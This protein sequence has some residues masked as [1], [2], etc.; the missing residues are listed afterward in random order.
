MVFGTCAT[1]IAPRAASARRE[2]ENAVSSP[3]MV[4]NSSIPSSRSA[5]RQLCIRQSGSSA[6]S[7]RTVGLARAV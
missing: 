1:R 6:P 7:S 3:P 2:A 4:T 5:F